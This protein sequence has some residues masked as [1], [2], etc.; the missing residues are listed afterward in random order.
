MVHMDCCFFPLCLHTHLHPRPGDPV[1]EVLRAEYTLACL[2]LA[3]EAKLCVTS[4]EGVEGGVEGR[5]GGGG[6]GVGGCNFA[7]AAFAGL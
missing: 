6:G 2:A 7:P 5:M 4:R 3:P 1:E